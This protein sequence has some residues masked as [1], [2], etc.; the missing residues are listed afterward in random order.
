MKKSLIVLLVSQLP[1]INLY[2]SKHPKKQKKELN[3]IHVSQTR[4]QV[5][6]GDGVVHNVLVGVT[7]YKEKE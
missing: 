2:P 4:K 6:D 5:K 1:V 7:Y 3:Y